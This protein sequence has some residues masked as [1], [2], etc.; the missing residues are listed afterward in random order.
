MTEK[1]LLDAI[2]KS[3]ENTEIP[4]SLQPQK[5][6]TKLTENHNVNTHQRKLISFTRKAAPVA[7]L[8]LLCITATAVFSNMNFEKRCDTTTESS[9]KTT[10]NSAEI[11]DTNTNLT[12]EKLQTQPKQDA[13]SLYT[14]AKSYDE[15]YDYINKAKDTS[16][17]YN[18]INESAME[19]SVEA[20][21]A[22]TDTVMAT[23]E[24]SKETSS[25]SNSGY[26]TTNL[27]IEGVD[28]SDK[29]KTDGRYIY[30]AVDS[31]VIITDT[32]DRHLTTVGSVVP[33]LDT[34]DYIREIYVDNHKLVLIVQHYDSSL[35]HLPVELNLPQATAKQEDTEFAESPVEDYFQDAPEK[36]IYSINQKIQTILHTY[37]IQDPTNPILEGT[38]TQ[39]GTYQTSRKIDNLIYLFTDNTISSDAAAKDVLPCVNNQTIPYDSVYLPKE[40]TQ[41]L[42]LSSINLEKPN[43][44]VDNIMI[45]HN[46]VNIY[47]GSDSIYLYHTDYKD[48][49]LT[50]IAGFSMKNGIIDAINATNVKGE[51]LDTFAINESE[52]CLRVL[53]T[54]TDASGE[55]SNNLFLL[56]ET[57]QP[58]GSLT[59]I[60]KGE[61]I[62]AARY[63]HDT[64][65]FITYRNTDPLFAVDISDTANPKI[66]GELQITG[67]S[68]YLHF[69]DDDKLLGIGYE[70]EPETG[71]I[72]GM[73]LAMFDI[74][75]PIDLKVIDTVVFNNCINSPALYNYKS[76]LADSNANLIGFVRDF[77]TITYDITFKYQLYSWEKDHFEEILS[78][79][80]APNANLEYLR[81]IYVD[82]IF[83]IADL[84]KISSFDRTNNYE[85]IEELT[86]N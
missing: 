76:V 2:K 38:I 52:G 66:L 18:E 23:A 45:F 31:K 47:V 55:K 77:E 22:L 17:V 51:I 15:L 64:A 48:D 81:G 3:A 83:Y 50:E 1:E 62:H 21:A 7:A 63:F 49:M 9:D 86:L 8:L 35:E 25:V 34:T 11:I 12:L 5:I 14:V 80:L 13:G 56:D 42:V 26:S 6:Q 79:T 58:I 71:N 41:G 61:Q 78:E 67:F 53:T 46:Y 84:R 33:E 70:S 54:S 73:K 68:E 40:G 19:E 65:Y 32:N 85:L 75:N 60:A 4:S 44:I 37:D 20:D 39:D 27:Q 82:D 59:D 28:E 43:Q 24:T 10:N 16:Y 74:S 69:W 30:T 36:P 29:I 57:M 72:I